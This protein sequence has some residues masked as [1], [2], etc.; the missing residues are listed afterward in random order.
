MVQDYDAI[1]DKLRKIEALF[2]GAATPGERAAADAA[3]DRIRRRLDEIGKREAPEEW[4]LGLHNEWSRRLFVALCRRYGLSP[5]RYP[6]QKRTS[7]MVKGPRSFMQETLIP[8][9]E[10]VNRV[11][12]QH[13]DEI[14]GEIIASAIS[15]ETRDVDEVNDVVGKLAT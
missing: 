7:I 10:R 2:A 1:L 5:F 11:L 6:G 3:R 14:A 4:R 12:L 8:E 13:L 15:S 9:F